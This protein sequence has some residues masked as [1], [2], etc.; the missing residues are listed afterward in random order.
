MT[1]RVAAGRSIVGRLLLA[2]RSRTSSQMRAR[3][4]PQIVALHSVHG[5]PG[6][7]PLRRSECIVASS[8]DWSDPGA[9]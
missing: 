1:I 9:S 4:I 3:F 2:R 8:T 7:S 6:F 5:K